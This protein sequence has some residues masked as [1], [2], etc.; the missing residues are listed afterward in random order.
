M[1]YIIKFTAKSIQM[2]VLMPCDRVRF[3]LQDI[4]KIRFGR[5]KR[6]KRKKGK[7][8]IRA[9]MVCPQGVSNGKQ[10]MNMVRIQD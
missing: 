9:S 8:T 2:E 5:M 3:T 6:D 1:C 10:L 4:R 7:P